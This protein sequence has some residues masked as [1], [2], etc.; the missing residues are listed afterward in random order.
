MQSLKELNA[1][2]ERLTSALPDLGLDDNQQ[3]EYSTML[4]WLQNQVETG[5]PAEWI[6]DECMKY[7]KVIVDQR[8]SL[9]AAS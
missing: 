2:V 1:L 6:V 7:F 5:E 8:I 4:L 9:R 3:E